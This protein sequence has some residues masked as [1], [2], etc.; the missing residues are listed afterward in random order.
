[1]YVVDIVIYSP[2]GMIIGRKLRQRIGV[3]LFDFL[4][5]NRKKSG[6]SLP[7]RQVL[8]LRAP[9]MV[10]SDGFSLLIVNST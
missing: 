4:E 9:E 7:K 5:S 2:K 8:C 6:K 1:M 10:K 3:V